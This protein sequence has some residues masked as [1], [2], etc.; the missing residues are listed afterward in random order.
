MTIA[1]TMSVLHAYLKDFQIHW[2]AND[3]EY[4]FMDI[5]SEW[6]WCNLSWMKLLHLIIRNEDV[7]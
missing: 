6:N 7:R 1:Q 5:P 2:R 4:V 3:L